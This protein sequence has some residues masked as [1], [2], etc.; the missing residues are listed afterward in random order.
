M[1]AV[2]DYEPRARNDP[3]VAIVDNYL[4]ASVPGLSPEKTVL[5]KAFPFCKW[6]TG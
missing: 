5:L 4:Q 6:L 3:M 1:S 2:Y